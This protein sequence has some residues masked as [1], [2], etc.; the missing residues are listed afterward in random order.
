MKITYL[1][2]L[3]G[4]LILVRDI[5]DNIPFYFQSSTYDMMSAQYICSGLPDT[6]CLYIVE[7]DD[8]YELFDDGTTRQCGAADEY[9]DAEVILA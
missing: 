7:D 3:P 4:D 1:Q 2:F 5:P 6:S 9:Y 8:L